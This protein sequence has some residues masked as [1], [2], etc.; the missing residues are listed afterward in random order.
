M[1]RLFGPTLLIILVLLFTSGA[2][3]G[4]PEGDGGIYIGNGFPG[5]PHFNLNVIA[6]KAEFT[7]PQQ[8][9]L[10]PDGITHKTNCSD[11]P[12]TGTCTP[13]YGGSIFVPQVPAGDK[14]TILMESGAKGPKG[15]PGAA[16][17]E[18]TDPC[19]QAFDGGP[20]SFRLPANAEGYM[21]YA[22][23]TGDPKQNPEFSF[24]DPELKYVMDESGNDL[25]LLG[26]VTD[27]KAFDF[28]G[29]PLP[30]RYDSSQKGKGV[31]KGVDITGLFLW[32]GAVCYLEQND[33]AAYCGW[34]DSNDDGTVDPNGTAC[35]T[36]YYCCLDEYGDGDYENCVSRSEIDLCPIDP[37]NLCCVDTDP[38]LLNYE[39]C[40]PAGE[41]GIC[42]E[43]YDYFGKMLPYI[44]MQDAVYYSPVTAGCKDYET[45]SGGG[46]WV[47]NIADFVGLLFDIEST[48]PNTGSSV[49]QL[50]F[51]PLP[52]NTK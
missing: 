17:L 20:A 45:A 21:V 35:S 22:R 26:L 2:N 8:E 41:E 51:Y 27:T 7:C 3:A 37:V 16:S 19:T 49:I 30:T 42:P 46:V 18:V 28:N 43:S 52:L 31:Q 50:R 34:V 15:N 48:G 1:R 11:C 9:F 32:S 24:T 6:K 39:Y 38:D 44:L 40:A 5:G 12:T 10:C 14:I 29:I 25:V 36:S 33:L 4:K 13:L 47:F 23:V